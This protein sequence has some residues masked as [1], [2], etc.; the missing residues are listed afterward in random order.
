MQ[1]VK[2]RWDFTS[3]CLNILSTGVCVYG[4]GI[5]EQF[6]C[7]W[8][9]IRY[10]LAPARHIRAVFQ[11]GTGGWW[12]ATDFLSVQ[13]LG[14]IQTYLESNLGVCRTLE[15]HLQACEIPNFSRFPT[16][17]SYYFLDIALAV[18]G[19]KNVSKIIIQRFPVLQLF[20]LPLFFFKVVI[21]SCSGRHLQL[22]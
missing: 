21:K 3:V 2:N 15:Y 20:G 9:K 18:K 19:Y 17:L 22:L 7:W 4:E 5:I 13:P 6:Y 1:A 12:I 10:I 8:A 11:A 16:F 14:F